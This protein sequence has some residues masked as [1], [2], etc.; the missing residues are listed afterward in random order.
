MNKCTCSSTLFSI[1]A[2][3]SHNALTMAA[4]ARWITPF[5]GPSWKKQ[6]NLS[7]DV[8]CGIQKKVTINDNCYNPTFDE[9]KFEQYFNTCK[10]YVPIWFDPHWLE[11]AKNCQN[12]QRCLIVASQPTSSQTPPLHSKLQD[13]KVRICRK[14]HSNPQLNGS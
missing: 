10:I 7:K 4:V 5:S 6:Q 1:L 3:K 11:T 12:H 8:T 2:H 14:S 9:K 13:K